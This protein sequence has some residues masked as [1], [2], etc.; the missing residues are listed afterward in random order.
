MIATSGKL[1]A[2]DFHRN[3]DTTPSVGMREK[4]RE[5]LSTPL[6]NDRFGAMTPLSVIE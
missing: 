6:K 1:R 3:W 5:R 2:L 4:D